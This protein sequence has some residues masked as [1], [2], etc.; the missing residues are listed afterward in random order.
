MA[1]MFLARRMRG[2]LTNRDIL[3]ESKDVVSRISLEN[4]SSLPAPKTMVKLLMLD[5]L[6]LD[7]VVSHRAGRHSVASL[8]LI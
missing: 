2:A 8:M 7:N 5:L 6:S 4:K 1:S 3:I